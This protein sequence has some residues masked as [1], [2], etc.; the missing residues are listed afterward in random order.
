M[1]RRGERRAWRILQNAGY[2]IVKRECVAEGTLA[3]DGALQTFSV[4]ADAI[5]SRKGRTFVAE[6]KG[7][8]LSARV[9][10]RATRRQLMEYA[11]VFPVDGVL[12]VDSRNRR[13]HTVR[14]IRRS[15]E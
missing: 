12:L 6:I 2:R 10:T 13:I 8:A 5:V 15:R 11:W 1:G 14:F 7:G 9:S 3:L 4:R